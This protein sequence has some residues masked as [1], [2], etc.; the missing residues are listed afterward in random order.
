MR[1][2][3]KQEKEQYAKYIGGY[4]VSISLCV[5]S[6]IGLCSSIYYKETFWII[7][8]AAVTFYWFGVVC[9]CEHTLNK[10]RR[11]LNL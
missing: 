11:D 9:S 6:A 1:E 8:N 7:F 3:N 2:A 5:L 10:M 4:Y